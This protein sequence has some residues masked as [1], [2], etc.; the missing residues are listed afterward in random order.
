MRLS[1]REQQ[2]LAETERQH[3][4]GQVMLAEQGYRELVALNPKNA[5]A[6]HYYGI[7][8]YQTDRQ[9][10]ALELMDRALAAGGPD[11]QLLSNRGEVLR[12]LGRLS[13][14]REAYAEVTRLAP[15]VPDAWN[16]L[17]L[18][19]ASEGR[20]EQAEKAAARCARL[21]P[22]ALE[23]RMV[24]AGIRWSAGDPEGSRE[25]CIDALGV[26]PGCWEA[27]LK[28]ALCSA[29]LGEPEQA[30]GWMERATA[31]AP[32]APE[33]VVAWADMALSTGHP[34]EALARLTALPAMHHERDDV[35]EIRG[36]TLFALERHGEARE[37][38]ARAMANAEAADV[39]AAAIVGI[40]EQLAWAEAQS[41]DL[42]AGVARLQRLAESTGAPALHESL[43]RLLATHARTDAALAAYRRAVELAPERG[44]AWR[45]VAEMHIAQGNFPAAR[46]ALARCIAIDATDGYAH[47]SLASIT[48]PAD[49]SEDQRAHL[50]ALGSNESLEVAER[51]AA[52]FAA[53]KLADDEDDRPVAFELMRRANALM[54]ESSPWDV[55][56]HDAW[57][58]RIIAAFPDAASLSPVSG[59]DSRV[60]VFIVGMPRSGTSLVEQ[61]LASHPAVAGAGE[62]EFFAHVRFAG[63]HA[64]YP[65]G[66]GSLDEP[67]ARDLAARYLARLHDTAG[68]KAGS[69]AHVT[70]KMPGN[71]LY[72][73]LV[74]ALFPAARIVWCRREPMA[75]GLSNY[76]QNFTAAAGNAWSFD[77][78]DIGH[79]TRAC[80]RLMAHWGPLLGERLLAVDYEA[81]V[82]AP[83]PG[84]E[85]LLAHVGL[86]W[87]D[88]CL[89]FHASR[90]E[91]R[92][93]SSFQVRQPLYSHAV[94]R[95]QQYSLQLA[96]LAAALE[97]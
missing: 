86:D 80:Q 74:C 63:E 88:D 25:A 7:L 65:E 1:P 24:L 29:S 22:T 81:L 43:G 37:C 16:N 59:S 36:R 83:R 69:F 64:L 17:A 82:A 78:A 2:L 23:P 39:E 53:G 30:Q 61:I 54:R 28:A 97:G 5:V 89:A 10:L 68:V 18:V 13:E 92:T 38:L 19:L 66:V 90:R 21:A 95:W 87:H 15:Q 11:P 27:A 57:V 96:P 32:D 50:L 77:L 33:V 12:L 56:A 44:D 4:A 71:F 79:Y 91:V 93:A 34:D 6:L 75:V 48:R 47:E 46:E 85:Q 55:A 9:D 14:A 40:T 94:A 84:V 73:G 31:I 52:L 35:V 20:F 49:W 70:D 45:G 42:D 62:V 58:D 41:G 3:Q 72:L 67:S 8:A 60:P 76:F 26:D 51:A